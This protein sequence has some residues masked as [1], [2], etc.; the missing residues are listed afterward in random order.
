MQTVSQ[1]VNDDNDQSE[2]LDHL[3]TL[4]MCQ[5]V[6]RGK[7]AYKHR[8]LIKLLKNRRAKLQ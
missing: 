3:N 6:A 1:E 7:Q 8:D 2:E 5:H 4:R